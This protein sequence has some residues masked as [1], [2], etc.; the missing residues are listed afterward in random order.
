MDMV[1][2]DRLA[3]RTGWILMPGRAEDRPGRD[4]DKAL[5]CHSGRR[6]RVAGSGQPAAPEA[7]LVG[8]WSAG[9]VQVQVQREGSAAEGA[10]QLSSGR[11]FRLQPAGFWTTHNTT[12]LAG[13]G[14]SLSRRLAR[15]RAGRQGLG[16]RLRNQGSGEKY[17]QD[18]TW[19][20]PRDGLAKVY[21]ENMRQESDRMRLDQLEE[22]ACR[23]YTRAQ[24]MSSL[25]GGCRR[26][27]RQEDCDCDWVTD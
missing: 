17:R 11:S 25:M 18:G 5:I 7:G 12:Q 13:S 4:G 6:S 21:I 10:V 19:E 14:S 8:D 1:G 3:T 15:P 27:H 9:Q 16:S 20:G 26:R 2:R 23:I 24:H 22:Q